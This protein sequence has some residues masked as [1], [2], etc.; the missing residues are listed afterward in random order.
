QPLPCTSYHVSFLDLIVSSFHPRGRMSH[1][2]VPALYVRA[3]TNVPESG[4]KATRH[5]PSGQQHRA[6]HADTD[7]RDRRRAQAGPPVLMIH[8]TDTGSRAGTGQ[9]GHLR[10]LVDEHVGVLAAF[11][12]DPA[13]AVDALG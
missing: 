10:A 5:A 3:R 12:D 9:V 6:K 8:R 4:T 1:G 7:Q 13:L 11:D 2:S